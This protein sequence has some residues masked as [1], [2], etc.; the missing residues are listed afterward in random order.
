[1]DGILEGWCYNF[2]Y[3][4]KGFIADNGGKFGNYKME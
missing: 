2:G 1:M 3:Q 4:T